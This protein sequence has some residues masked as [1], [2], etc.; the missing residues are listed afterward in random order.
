MLRLSKGTRRPTIRSQAP[1]DKRPKNR[2]SMDR[3]VTRN[4]YEVRDIAT[5]APSPKR[6]RVKTR[7]DLAAFQADL[8][9]IRS[10]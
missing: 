1:A 4:Q 5:E 9:P 3:N 7:R 6:Q 2:M 8:K 10:K